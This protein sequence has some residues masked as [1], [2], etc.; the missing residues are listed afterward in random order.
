MRQRRFTRPNH[1][2]RQPTNIPISTSTKPAFPVKR[3]SWEEM[4]RRRA[5]G[6]CFKC[7][8]KFA[9]SHKCRGPQLLLLEAA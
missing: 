5:M 7:D 9:A 1:I 8:D 6:L 3:L 4:Q 2:N